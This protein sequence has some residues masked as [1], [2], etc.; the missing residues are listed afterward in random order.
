MNGGRVLAVTVGIVAILAGL[1][2]SG[3]GA[4][5]RGLDALFD[6][7][8]SGLVQ[9]PGSAVIVGEV[10]G[11]E[12]RIGNGSYEGD[13]ELEVA[14]TG[15]EGGPV[16]V[17]VGRSADVA[18]Y[19]DGA[20]R[21]VDLLF[22]APGGGGVPGFTSTDPRIPG[23]PAAQAIWAESSAGAGEQSIEWSVRGG[24]WTFVVM[25]ADGRR[26]VVADVSATTRVPFLDWAA[27]KST[28]AVILGGGVLILV[29]LVLVVLGLRGRGRSRP[30]GPTEF[31]GDAPPNPVGKF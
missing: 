11:E 18:A 13:F 14:A 8:A 12:F 10:S 24:Q 3:G 20:D 23:P 21:S 6:G 9:G 27:G 31:P 4:L 7:G 15:R 19:L 28:N 26:G 1:T 17:G 30:R 2:L 25:R 29:G 22:S 5:A 16:F